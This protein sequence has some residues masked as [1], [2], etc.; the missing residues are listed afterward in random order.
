MAAKNQRHTSQFKIVRRVMLIR[1]SIVVFSIF[2]IP[3]SQAESVRQVQQEDGVIEFSNV[4][5]ESNR[6]LT[7]DRKTAQTLIYKSESNAVTT[8]SDQKPLDV[9]YEVLKFDCFA[10]D[11]HS[12][13]DWN[14]VKL[15][16]TSYATAIN[17]AAK[18]HHVDPALIRALIHAESSFNP[19]AVSTQGA[20]GLMQL[21]PNTAKDLGVSNAFNT[22]QNIDGGV[23][24]LAQLLR[25]FNG[26]IKL[27]T[28]AYNAGP[29]AVKKYNGIPPYSETQV[30]V[31]RVGILHRRYQ[32]AG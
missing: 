10:C 30:Y 2:T 3:F 31:E 5:A 24:Y 12:T 26:N 6:L 23:K 20:Q 17:E 27:A 22:Q 21:M 32:R 7:K 14:H 4:D 25:K 28:A 1:I 29:S 15:D 9:A 13:I 18:H 8:F 19:K 11:P 16:L